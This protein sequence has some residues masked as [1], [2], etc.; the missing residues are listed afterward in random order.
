MSLLKRMASA[1]AGGKPAPVAA[2]RVEPDLGL[3]KQR[4]RGFSAAQRGRLTQSWDM[5]ST[6]AD[7]NQEIYRDHHTLRARAREQSINSPY[8]KRFYRLL[9]QNV[10]GPFGIALQSKAVMANGEPNRKAR[11]MIERE[12]RKFCRRGNCDVTGKYSFTTFMNLW[13]ESLARDG[14]VM[15]RLIRNWP[16]RWGFALQILEIDRLDLD[17]NQELDNGNL[18]RMGVEQDSWERPVAYWLLKNH[19]GDVYQ[20]AEERYERVP[21]TELLH[22]YEPWRAHQSRGFTWTH[23]AAAELH[24]LDEYRNAELVKSEMQAKV[25]GVYEQDAEW[26]EPPDDPDDDVDVEE[27]LEAGTNKLIP[28]GL[29]YK[30]LPSSSPTQFAPFTK[31]GLRGVAAGFGPS[32]NRLAHDL[33]GVSFS[34][35]RSGE[36]DERDFYK[37][38]QQFVISSLLEAVGDAWLSMSLLTGAIPLPPRNFEI[39]SELCWIPR[40]WDWVDPLKDSKAATESI[41]NLTK[42]IG[43]Y[44]RQAGIDPDD[45][46]DEL[47]REK[48]ELRRRGLAPE[49][50]TPP[51]P[52]NV[53]KAIL[54][55]QLLAED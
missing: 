16:N 37:S 23:A 10:V 53:A 44:V 47:E 31:Q 22:T 14:E 45:H 42:S 54:D 11:R 7:A 20:R 25:T 19:P 12:W 28:Y 32:Y 27:H 55:A 30:P 5:R 26:L 43:H 29:K 49:L 6:N 21:A 36:L 46:W 18:I 1:L 9:K 13:L 48:A 2:A 4:S 34:S 52:P 39:Y 40:G 24:H 41:T 35:L 15:V 33:E 38:T 17:L 8:A 3:G 51:E 50:P